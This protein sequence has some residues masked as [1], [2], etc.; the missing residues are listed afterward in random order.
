MESIRFVYLILSIF[1]LVI[2]IPIA[3]F[4]KKNLFKAVCFVFAISLGCSFASARKFPMKEVK[5]AE[6]TIPAVVVPT[7][8]VV[9]TTIK[10]TVDVKTIKANEVKDETGLKEILLKA[11]YP[12]E[13]LVVFC[14]NKRIEATERHPVASILYKYL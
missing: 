3:H 11:F 14:M 13:K 12:P 7:R 10:E 4:M 1:L 6:N 2:E 9:E 8:E 5:P